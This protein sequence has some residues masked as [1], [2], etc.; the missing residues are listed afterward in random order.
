MAG[1]ETRG[2]CNDTNA[3]RTRPQGQ[4]NASPSNGDI[5]Q[6]IREMDQLARYGTSPQ[7]AGEEQMDIG[8]FREL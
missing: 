6:K 7:S 8:R 5:A 2:A 1:A 3:P 4:G